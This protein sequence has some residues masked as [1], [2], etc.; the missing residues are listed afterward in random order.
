MVAPLD[1]K[2]YRDL[3]R[4]KGQVVSIAFVISSGVALLVMSMS[5][6]EALGVTSD[7]YY[8]RYRYGHVFASVK[9]A[10]R[11]LDQRI[12]SLPGVQSSELRI[13]MQAILDVDDF[14]EPLTGRL[15]SIPEGRQP[16]L[17]RLYVIEGR[18]IEPGR[19]DEVLVNRSFAE[20]HDL[21][22]GDTIRATINGKK[23]RLQIVGTA[24]SPEFIY[25]ISP[26]AIMPDKKRY[27]V[28]WMGE[29]AM[30]AAFDYD[31]AFNEV[32]LSVLR[33]VDT[34]QVVFA[35]DELL[36]GYGGTGAVDREDHLSN[37][38]IQNELKQQKASARILPAI[39]LVVAAFLTNTVL[40]RLIITERNEIG[41]MKAFG[42]SNR[43]V[44]W[45]YAKFVISIAV[46][47]VLIGWLLGALL[48]RISTYS[49]TSNL[50]LPMLIYRP[51]PAAFI[52]G[53]LVSI[54]VALLATARA[55]R[56]AAA[57]PPIEAMNPPA[58][59]VFTSGNSI[60]RRLSGVLDEPSRIIL[61]QIV[62][63]PARALVTSIGFAGAVA[64]M[65]MSLYFP[66]AIDEMG[67]V[68][69][70][71]AQ[72]ADL[73][74]GFNEPQPSTA[75]HSVLDLPGVLG[76]ETLR[77]VSVDLASEHRVHRGSIQGLPADPQLN[78]I[79]DVRRGVR[80]VPDSGL[81]INARLAEKL[82]VGIGD[83]L[84]V[85]VLEG[86]R[87]VL[88]LP[89]ADVFQSYIGMFAYMNIDTMNRLLLE[90]PMTQ[91]VSAN[92]DKNFEPELLRTLKDVPAIAAVAVKSVA[93][94]NYHRTIGETMMIFVGFFATFSF[95]LG[96]G[97][98]YNAQRIGLSERG[99]E[100]STLR[101]LGF[102]RGEAAYIL[103]GETALLACLAL[104]LGC[105]LGATITALFMGTSGFQTEL[106][107]VPLT[108]HPST[109]G[110]AAGSLLLACAASCIATQ[111]WV[112]HLDLIAVL[113]TRE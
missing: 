11:T 35:L 67:R 103:I 96:F 43:E 89:V 2:L 39:F 37:W 24:T 87:P 105:I 81:T 42:Y 111:R 22:P 113:K 58:P 3:W 14:A 13:S 44:G 19:T 107:R 61:R 57:L 65:V 77:F 5:T 16:D 62:R 56:S 84:E 4:L 18:L 20:A 9:R 91:Y 101:V 95:A 70:D 106:M 25:V 86:R 102:S 34:R 60:V 36:A 104:P 66:D 97:V 110:A 76:A 41:L 69:F 98:T 64:M 48:G 88:E 32:S 23:R 74:I 51:S 53:A 8:E 68:H 47:G 83:L 78:R 40:S 100:L 1:K 38:F 85:R 82:G 30:E 33:G 28:I 54:A 15:V 21:Q 112:N 46:L 52:T 109:Y 50:N 7:A 93:L 45:H 10:P 79:Y 73:S 108:I 6:Y 59:P 90:R 49:Y 63:W 71:E 12:R 31:G 80:P 72:R 27:G 94:E 26:F 99:R 29:K 75:V 17:N 92:I 55:V